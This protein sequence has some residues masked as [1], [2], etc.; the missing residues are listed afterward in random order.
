MIVQQDRLDELNY[1]WL[2]Y[3]TT[4]AGNDYRSLELDDDGNPIDIDPTFIGS[5]L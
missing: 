3:S 4:K 2:G 5:K 1:N